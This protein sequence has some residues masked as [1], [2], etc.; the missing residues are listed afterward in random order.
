LR[1]ELSYGDFIDMSN[2]TC[3]KCGITLENAVGNVRCLCGTSSYSKRSIGE[4]KRKVE[5]ATER[6]KWLM[7]ALWLLKHDS[8]RGIGDTALRLFLATHIASNINAQLERLLKQCSCS[9]SDAVNQL[10]SDY[11]YA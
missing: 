7:G 5:E 2:W 3:S 1:H 9:R 10:N 6:H 11:P 4:L 8:D